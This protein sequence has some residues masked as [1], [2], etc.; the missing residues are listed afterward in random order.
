MAAGS[1]SPQLQYF[2]QRLSGFSTNIFKLEPQNKSDDI[3][4]HQIIRFSL[5]SN[6][7]LNTRS[8][9]L[10]FN[11]ETVGGAGTSKAR[12][13]AK[14]DTLIERVEITAGGVQISQGSNYYNVLR[15]AKDALMGNKCNPV[16]GHPDLIRNFSPISAGALTANNESY[17]NV[18]R[19]FCIDYWEGFLGTCEPKI[20]DASIL[21][22]LVISIYLADNKVLTTSDEVNSAA[23]MILETTASGAATFKL[24][25]VCA[26]IE[27]IGLADATYDNLVASMMSAKGFLEIPFKQYFAFQNVHSGNT[28]F[29]LA[30]QSLDR[31]WVATR[32]ADF[33]DGKAPKAVN[34]SGVGATSIDQLGTQEKYL[35]K[36]YNFHHAAAGGDANLLQYQLQFNGAYYPQFPATPEQMYQISKNSTVGY[37]MDEYSLQ[38]YLSNYFVQCVR[39][40]MPDSEYS[41]LLSGLDTRSVNLQ[42]QYIT[43][44]TLAG[45]PTINIFCECT[46]TLRCGPGKMIEIVV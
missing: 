8:F 10:H 25:D 11:A 22:D 46:S 9:A 41:R 28:R 4:A 18:K 2:L 43:T 16:L 42:G 35:G 24:S 21:P 34:G 29:S 6:A 36:Y 32:T 40:N 19:P 27:T 39:L 30:C 20:L 13:P 7:L 1:Y 45:T 14:I 33:D 3:T 31:V 38:A 12:L 44:G 17:T 26:T 5:P 15:H 37:H 23:N